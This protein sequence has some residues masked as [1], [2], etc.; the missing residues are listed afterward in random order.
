M[1]ADKAK[2]VVIHYHHREAGYGGVL[3]FLKCKIN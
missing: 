1:V 2:Q 3:T